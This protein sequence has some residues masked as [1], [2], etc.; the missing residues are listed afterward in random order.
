MNILILAYL[1][2]AV[3]WALGGLSIQLLVYMCRAFEWI[4]LIV[5]LAIAAIL[6][7]LYSIAS[8]HIYN[9]IIT[10]LLLNH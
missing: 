2:Y 3:I 5:W 4:G 1:N 7:Y 6:I 9:L 10:H 8:P